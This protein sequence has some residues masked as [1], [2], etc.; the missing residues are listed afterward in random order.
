MPV[1]PE[2]G[3]WM[4]KWGKVMRELL[5]KANLSLGGG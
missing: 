3:Q 2:G 5:G 4:I 1:V